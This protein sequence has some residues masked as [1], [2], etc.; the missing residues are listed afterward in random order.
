VRPLSPCATTPEPVLQS[1]GADH[2]SPRALE[3]VLR[4][5]RSHSNEKPWTTTREQPL[6]TAAGEK[7]SQQ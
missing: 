7:P 2:G 3:P 4:N 1:P 5:K 6:L